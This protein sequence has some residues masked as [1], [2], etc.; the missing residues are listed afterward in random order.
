V[1]SLCRPRVRP[2]DETILAALAPRDRALWATALYA[3]LR[4][5]E[6]LALRW[7]DIDLAAGVIHVRRGW[8]MC[9]GEIE[10]KSRSGKRNVPIPAVLRDHLIERKLDGGESEHVFGG[11]EAAR[12]TMRHG[13]AAM[14]AAGLKPLA[15]HDCR[16]TYASFMIAAGVNAKSLSVYMGHSAI[17]ITLDLYG[18]LM[19]GNETEAAGL[20]DTYL[21]RSAGDGLQHD[22][23]AS[24]S[25]A[26]AEPNHS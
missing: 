20:L 24:A 10:P 2:S 3:G 18:H 4:R 12:R 26:V 17:G 19:P 23:S 9:A 6:L 15:I 22:C 14:I 21:A 5:G 16:H 8:D 11:A 13:T 25:I 7:E 1:A